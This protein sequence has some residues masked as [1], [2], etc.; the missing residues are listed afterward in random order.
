[1][2]KEITHQELE[3]LIKNKSPIELIDVREQDEYN[4]IRIPQAKLL[5]L[6][7]FA[8]RSKEIDWTKPVYIYCRTGGRSGQACAWLESEG[9]N[10]INVSG[11]IKALWK[12]RSDIL[13]IDPI[14]DPR[15]LG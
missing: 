13:L 1:M 3:A 9:K 8:H 11:S 5:P 12:N 7:A 4:M 15:Y 10:A 14:F 2:Y 6:S